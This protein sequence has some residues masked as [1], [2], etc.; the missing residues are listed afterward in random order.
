MSFKPP[1]N[2]EDRSYLADHPDAPLGLVGAYVG[3]TYSVQRFVKYTKAGFVDHLMIRRHDGKPI[4]SW[5]DMQRIKNE[6]VENGENR[7][8]VQVFPKQ[9]DLVDQ[10]NMYHIYVYR[11]GYD[12]PFNLN[13]DDSFVTPK[14]VKD[15][16]ST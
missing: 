13:E 9:K 14:P 2:W 11:K 1:Q 12:L 3:K 5:S 7:I 6:C 8:G 4:Q 10:A 15:E 16:T